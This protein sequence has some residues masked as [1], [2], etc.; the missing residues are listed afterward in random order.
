MVTHPGYDVYGLLAGP[1]TLQADT[2]P[3]ALGLTSKLA[4]WTGGP[5]SAPGRW[6][7]C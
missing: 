3:R 1:P 7:E 5:G 4:A 6:P 2:G